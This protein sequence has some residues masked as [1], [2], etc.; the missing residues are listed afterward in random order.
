M[1]AIPALGRL[2]DWPRR[3]PAGGRPRAD[4]LE[5]ASRAAALAAIGLLACAHWIP[6]PLLLD[7]VGKGRD[8]AA[9]G[10]DSASRAAVETSRETRVGGYVGV[11]HTYPS[12]VTVSNP[13][14]TQMTVT[15]FNWK[16]MPFKSPIY[17]G[18]RAQRVPSG[19]GLGAMLDFT[20][21]KA[22]AVPEDVATFTGTRNGRPVTPSA[23]IGD[24]FKHL[25]FSHGHNILT[26][27]GLYRFPALLGGVRPYV[28]LGAGIT[29]PHTE[30]GFRDENART[31]EYQFAGFA[32]QVVVGLEIPA[33]PAA[34][35]LEW[36]L[37]YAPYSVPLSHEPYGWLLVTDLWRQFRA[38]MTGDKPPG[39]TL[40]TTLL[41]HHGVAGIMARVSRPA[42]T[43]R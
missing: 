16:G 38:W 19:A 8:Q 37:T 34:A 2:R 6:P 18:V 1:T 24:V 27:N 31:Y 30:V 29:L 20:H 21:A 33:G 14:S 39:G 36:K 41:S 22:I 3:P 28:G 5:G 42:T 17:Y 4:A 32:G 40:R 7:H 35:F 43:V 12:A 15:G 9:S 11:S 23:R 13:P 25:E 26:A 10:A